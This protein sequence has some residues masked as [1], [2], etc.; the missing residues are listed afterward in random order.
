MTGRYREA[1]DAIRA[2]SEQVLCVA[3]RMAGRGSMASTVEVGD[4]IASLRRLM[5]WHGG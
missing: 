1:H 3:L 2:A 5:P 4:A